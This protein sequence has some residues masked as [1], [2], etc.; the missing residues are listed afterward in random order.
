MVGNYQQIVSIPYSSLS[1]YTDTSSGVN[2]NSTQYRYKVSAV[3]TCGVESPLSSFHQTIHL[4]IPV[5]SGNTADLVWQAYEG[6]PSNFY[7]RILRDSLSNLDW[8]IIDSVSSTTLVYTDVNVPS[9]VSTNRYLIEIAYNGNCDITKQQS[10]NTTRSN[11]ATIAGG[12]TGSGIEE[13]ILSK[14][15]VYPTHLMNL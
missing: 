15:E 6:F 3:D 5:Y 2:P 11:R 14:A 1:T 12:S 10:H 4:N 7:Y 13:M 8:Q 9:T